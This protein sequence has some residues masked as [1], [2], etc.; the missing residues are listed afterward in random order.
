[1]TE[2]TAGQETLPDAQVLLLLDAMD[3]AVEEA[4]AIADV[5]AYAVAIVVVAIEAVETI[6][7]AADEELATADEE[8][9]AVDEDESEVESEDELLDPAAAQLPWAFGVMASP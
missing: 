8:E 1:M 3:A 2:P 6:L 5:V 7:A 4:E 9:T